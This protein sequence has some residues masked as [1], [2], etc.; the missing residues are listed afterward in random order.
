MSKQTSID[1]LKEQLT[2]Q[3]PTVRMLKKKTIVKSLSFEELSKLIETAKQMHKEEIETAYW[4]GGQNIP[5]TEQNCTDYYNQ[6]F[7]Q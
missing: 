4:D 5:L 1:W 6:T 7:K 3:V 2:V